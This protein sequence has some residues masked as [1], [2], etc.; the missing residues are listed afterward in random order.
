M[1]SVALLLPGF[2]HR[3]F[4]LLSAV[5]LFFPIKIYSQS[6]DFISLGVEDGLSQSEA[7]CVF[8]D[9]RGYLWVGTAGGGVCSFDGIKFH[10]YGTKDGLAGQI[11]TSI[12]EDSTGK[13]WFGTTNGGAAI[14]D[15]KTFTTIDEKRGLSEDDVHAIVCKKDA[16]WIGLG[17][18]IYEYTEKNNLLYRIAAFKD[19]NAICIDESNTAWIGTANGFFC[20]SNG[21]KDS[22]ALPVNRNG[23]YSILCVVSDQHGLIYIGTND[24][25]L[26]YRPA[27][28]R[29]IQSDLIPVLEGKQVS[30]IFIDHLQNVWVGT[31]NNL[32]VKYSGPGN[33][34]MYDKSNGMASE[35]ICMITE[36]DTRHMWFGTREESL[37]RL[38]SESFSYYG[39]IPGMGSGTVFQ[40]VEDQEG[41]MWVGSNEDGLVKYSNGLSVKILNGGE[42]FRQ[43]VGL[44]ED[45]QGKMWVGH[46][47]GLTCLV[48]DRPVKN[49]LPGIRVRSLLFDS[50][51][52][53]WI[54]T[55]GKGLFCYSNDRME[56]YTAENGSMP[57]NF[58]HS[59]CEDHAGNIWIGTGAGL[60][61]YD[62]NFFTAY[63]IDSGLCNLY[64]GSI[65]VDPSDNVWFHT[66]LCVMR[67]D[68]KKFISYTEQEGLA[69]NTSFLVKADSLGQIWVGSNKGID[70][71]RVD[72]N[73]AVLSVKNYS[74]NEGFRGIECNSRAVCLTRDGCLW[75]GTVRGVIRYNPAK[76]IDNNVVP[77]IHITGISLF[78]EQTDWTYSGAKE[79]GWFHLPD[80]LQLDYERNHL[81]FSYAGIYLQSPQSTRYQ[82]ML[83]GFDSTWQPAT[84]TSATQFTYTNLPPGTY[85]FRVRASLGDGRWNEIP[86]VSCAITIL[87]PPPPIWQTWWFITA[88]I[89]VIGGMLLFIILIRTARIKAHRRLLEAEV[90]ER[91]IEISR[92]NE[93]KTVMLKEIHHRVKNNLQVISSLLNLQADGISDKRVLTLFEDCRHR[94][95]SM[96]LIHQK[97]YQSNNLV[98]IDIR[99]YIDE[100]IRSLIDAYDTNKSIHLHTD[101][102]DHPFRID[103]IVPLGL[104]LNEIISNSLKYAF[105]GQ[106][107]GDLYISLHKKQDNFY[108]LEVSD[109]GKGIPSHINIEDAKTLGMQL[110]HMLSGQ[111]N[112]KVVL[113]QQSGL[114]YRIEFEEE[115][116][117]RF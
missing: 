108:I 33:M 94:V 107:E 97:M 65:T 77:L 19:L 67:F 82:F 85:T 81:T 90:R 14:Y 8:Q 43:P 46:R 57:G 22:V 95:N 72:A 69:S 16:V 24:G 89:L 2:I 41:S 74:R 58:V 1:R 86:A 105:E 44:E 109:N 102:E 62:G 88:S 83:S 32:A 92:Q 40:I 29:F 50:K 114:K 78:L 45:A 113:S 93:E 73:G 76:D 91:T 39:N 26:I 49:L 104:I 103:T 61:K 35:T 34:V 87:P 36:D 79:S 98:N 116:K 112:G 4:F 53:L 23:D 55:W 56:S 21:R 10:E 80:K 51:G 96:A 101:I 3:K 99:N 115:L 31:M 52:K 11:I 38:R 17:S 66:D 25:L 64:I 37:V 60:I 71:L 63:N 30:T 20:F 68:G 84:A 54:G 42:I 47:D 27:D 28:G 5:L 7:R 117:D 106:T 9:S 48:N 111:I 100:L 110:I 18:G 59:F 6:Y 70:R 15:G 13:M 75:F 12:A